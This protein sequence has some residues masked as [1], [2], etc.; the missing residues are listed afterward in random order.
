MICNEL[1]RILSFW[2]VQNLSYLLSHPF[3][4]KKDSRQAGMTDY[5]TKHGSVILKQRFIFNSL[6]VHF[7]KKTNLNFAG[8]LLTGRR[9][10]LGRA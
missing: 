2:L 7:F 1:P 8:K 6:R 9:L 5:E 10:L 3:V 4:L